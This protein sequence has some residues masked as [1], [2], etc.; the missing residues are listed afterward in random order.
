L[1]ATVENIRIEYDERVQEVIEALTFLWVSSLAMRDLA[2][3][4]SDIC[5][6]NGIEANPIKYSTIMINN[7]SL[8]VSAHLFLRKMEEVFPEICKNVKHENYERRFEMIHFQDGELIV[9]EN[10][11][12]NLI[13]PS[14][15]SHL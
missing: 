15:K 14:I 13:K 8:S 11:A 12:R 6:E 1:I 7:L 2:A 10:N 4:S 9:Y 3:K 5:R